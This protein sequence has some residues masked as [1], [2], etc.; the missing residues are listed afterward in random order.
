MRNI[1]KYLMLPIIFFSCSM[2]EKKP[3]VNSENSDA[4]M[5]DNDSTKIVLEKQ[6][7]QGYAIKEKGLDAISDYKYGEEDFNVIKNI[8]LDILKKSGYQQVDS[9]V[10]KNKVKEI[11]HFEKEGADDVNFLVE[12]ACRM[13]KLAYQTDENYVVS[14]NNPLFIDYKNQII[15]EALFIPESID[16]KKEFPASFEKENEIVK[17]KKIGQYI[18]EVIRWRDVKSLNETQF[19][20]REKLINRN[21]YIFNNSKSSL[22][23]LKFNDKIFLESL[24]KTFG[25]VKD[26]SLI[27]YVLKNNYKDPQEFGKILINKR[28]NEEI[29]FNNNVMNIIAECS[30]DEQTQYLRSIE[31][32]LLDEVENKNIFVDTNFAKKAEILGKLSYH[33]TIL[34]SKNNMFYNFF[35][36]LGSQSGGK[37][38]DEE[39]KRANYYNI[40]DFKDLWEET[41]AG[42]VSTP[43]VE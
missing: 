16:Y 42:G 18:V 14:N 11:F 20:N 1:T 5:I 3:G 38:Y 41:K 7:S 22:T 32:F 29:I 9:E 4:I 37:D 8:S 26:K 12:F 36:V 17:E 30:E 24:V 43:G 31:A 40:S 15:L 35:S 19:Q 25:Y 39:F 2:E 10:F 23:W 13:K 21:K 27:T 33:A 34:G 6:L 28:C